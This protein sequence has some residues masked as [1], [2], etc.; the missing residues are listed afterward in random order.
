M[1]IAGRP[2]AAAADLERRALADVTQ[3]RHG[4]RPLK[5]AG[6]NEGLPPAGRRVVEGYVRKHAYTADRSRELR[7]KASISAGGIVTRAIVTVAPS[8]WAADVGPG[9]GLRHVLATEDQVGDPGG[10]RTIR[11][12]HV[13]REQDQRSRRLE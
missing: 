13:I 2:P 9:R 1:V 8:P 12:G 11:R 5:D 6:R 10:R 7:R 4:H 3:D